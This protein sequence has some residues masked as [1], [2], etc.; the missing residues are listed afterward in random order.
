M[1]C[2]HSAP[3]PALGLNKV[4]RFGEFCCCCCLPLLPAVFTQPWA[5]LLAESCIF[6]KLSGASA[7][8]CHV[9]GSLCSVSRQDDIDG[10]RRPQRGH[11]V[12][13]NNLHARHHC[14]CLESG[15]ANVNEQGGNS[16]R[17]IFGSYFAALWNLITIY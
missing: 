15:S 13:Q 10:N 11:K 16:I 4:S 5:H 1:S 3:Q 6:G 17:H 2:N 8:P 14:Q 12:H 7:I 9:Q